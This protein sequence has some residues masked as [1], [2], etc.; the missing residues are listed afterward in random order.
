MNWNKRLRQIHRWL[1]LTFTVA[2]IANFVVM[3]QG[4]LAQWVG[5]LTLF[6]LVPLLLTGLYLFAQ[7]YATR[8]YGA[9]LA[10]ERKHGITA[11]LE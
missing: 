3:G 4:K 11:L 8:W 10:V 6:P 9:R 5:V 2:V 7:P 1:S